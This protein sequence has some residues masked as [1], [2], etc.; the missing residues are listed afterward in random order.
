MLK[1]AR[2]RR[3]RMTDQGPLS[4]AA[5]TT[6]LGSTPCDTLL[7]CGRVTHETI[8]RAD[9]GEAWA[10]ARQAEGWLTEDQASALF[11][12]AAVVPDGG[13]IVEIGSF[14]GRSAIMLAS[15]A[16]PD[17]DVVCIDPHLGSDRGPQEIA[18]QPGLGESDNERFRA[19]LERAGV[20]HRVRHVR[21]FSS[22]AFDHVDGSIDV[23]YVDGAHRFAPARDDIVR[24]GAR[25][26]V[27]GQMFVHDA[28]SSIGVTFALL[29]STVLDGRW[30]YLGRDGSLA[31]YRREQSIDR[32]S[33]MRQVA[34]LPW[35][36]RNVVLKVLIVAKLRRGPFP[37]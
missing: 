9:E 3:H 2:I 35:F 33:A 23:L 5:G 11:T 27:G 19:N 29:T 37:Y 30:C 13:Q 22:D 15:A 26:P 8:R 21:E 4:G 18:A 6:G 12:A 16:R 10:A 32:W 17:V 28:F 1:R 7:C 24:W 20:A 31:R 14:R 36:V 25:V 34:Q